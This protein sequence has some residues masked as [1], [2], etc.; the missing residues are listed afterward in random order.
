MNN[1][2]AIN[3][4]KY[5]KVDSHIAK[6]EALDLAI[7]AL[8]RI[9]HDDCVLKE[10]GKC[11]YKETGCS[12]CRIKSNLRELREKAYTREE[13]KAW[14]YEI[15]LNNCGNSLEWACVEL[16]S[17]LDGFERF[18]EDKRKEANNEQC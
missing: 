14:L 10:F 7:K 16:I 3:H 18:V 12:D 17:R 11:S 8:E 2:D 9:D 15:A 1:R 13:L 4:L 5:L 6:A